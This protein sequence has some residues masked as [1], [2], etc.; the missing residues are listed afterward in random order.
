MLYKNAVESST[1]DLLKRICSIKSFDSFGLGGGTN[2]A[3]RMGHRLSV[4]LDFFTNVSYE[5]AHIQEVLILKKNVFG[6]Y[7]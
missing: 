7:D 3:L 6:F 1:L 5:N 2:L 4:D